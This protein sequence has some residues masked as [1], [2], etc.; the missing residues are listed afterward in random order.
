M[1]IKVSYSGRGKC[2]EI[3]SINKLADDILIYLLIP[4]TA[5]E[6]RVGHRIYYGS[7]RNGKVDNF[8]NLLQTEILL[9]LSVLPSF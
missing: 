1:L 3:E 7:S 2:R 9:L 8:N 6:A 5:E 4:H